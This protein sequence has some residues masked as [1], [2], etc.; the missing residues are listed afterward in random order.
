MAIIILNWNGWQDT[1]ECLES[2]QHINYMDYEVILVDNCSTNDSVKIFQSWC[3]GKVPVNTKMV[4]FSPENKPVKYIEYD[5]ISA[6]AVGNIDNKT[7][8]DPPQRRLV[9][10]QTG[11]NLGFA[12][13]NNVGIRYALKKDFDYVWL[14]NND[15]VIDRDS[16][17]EM[18]KLAESDENIG[19]VGSKLVD[20]HDPQKIQSIGENTVFPQLHNK[21]PLITGKEDDFPVNP[22]FQNGCGLQVC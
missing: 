8:E 3:D 2:V 17:I 19:M 15:T 14:L 22:L 1:L 18:I 5:R 12:G 6:E 16:L 4:K 13:G 9:I 10:I 20:Y 11:E 21:I 7:E